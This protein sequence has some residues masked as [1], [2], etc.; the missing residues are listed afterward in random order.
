[1]PENKKDI[2]S[3]KKTEIEEFVLSISEPKYRANQV[4]KWIQKAGIEDFSKMTDV[5]AKLR[6]IFYDNFVIFNCAIEKKLISVY[7]NTIKYLFRLF[8]GEFIE[9]VLMKYKYGYTLC[10]SMQAGCRMGCRFCATAV[11]GLRR[12]LYPS[13]MLSQIHA[14]EKDAGVRVSH[15]VLMGMGEPLDNF[16]NTPRFLELVSN[17]DGLNLGMRNISL[18]T[19]G[20]V[21][22]IDAL[23]EKRL[24]LT[25]SVSLHAPTDEI[26]REIMPITRKYGVDGILE[27]CRRYT[28]A[29]SRRIS[30]EYALIEGLNDSDECAFMLAGKLKG[31][32]CHINLI[33]A[34]KIEGQSFKGSG[35][36]RTG[37][38]SA[39]LKSKGLNVTVRRRLGADINASCGQLR[40]NVMQN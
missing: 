28:D 27:A 5:S 3:M 15:V 32:L 11:G 22:E 30:F 31:M 23:A 12:D 14:A 7:D 10:I 34:N 33:P 8:D 26:R 2:K 16:D 36:E 19:C 21:P 35:N 9:A 29:T 39:I 25:L 1:M 13:E 20:L 18:S 38:F 40:G 17:G 37:G 24:Q 6:K 4:F